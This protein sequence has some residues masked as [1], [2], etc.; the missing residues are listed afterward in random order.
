MATETATT[1]ANEAPQDAWA[2]WQREH[3]VLLERATGPQRVL[4]EATVGDHQDP[5]KSAAYWST[6]R[7]PG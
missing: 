3:A 5:R 4:L 7:G 1:Q 2:R 6:S